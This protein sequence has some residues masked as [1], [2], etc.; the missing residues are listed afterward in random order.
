VPPE[1]NRPALD[2]LRASE[3][4]GWPYCGEPMRTQAWP[5]PWTEVVSVEQARSLEVELCSK[6]LKSHRSAPPKDAPSPFNQ[7]EEGEVPEV[8]NEGNPQR[9]RRSAMNS[10]RSAR[11]SRIAFEMQT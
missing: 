8:G 5:E 1:C 9:R 4:D 10:A 6:D 2:L 7:S 3:T 11:V